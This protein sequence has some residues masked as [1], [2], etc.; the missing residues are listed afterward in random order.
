MSATVLHLWKGGEPG[1]AVAT[2]ARQA[3]RGDRVTLAVLH[4]V[5]PPPV[6]A[7][8]AVTRVPEELPWE[9]L[10]ELIFQADQVVAW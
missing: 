10:L 9:G 5:P 4:G 6:G 3:A 8:I 7:G 1:L 2:M